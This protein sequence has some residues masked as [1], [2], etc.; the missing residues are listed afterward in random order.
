MEIIEEIY[1][2]VYRFVSPT[3]ALLYIGLDVWAGGLLESHGVTWE[4]LAPPN[5]P[6][7][8]F[9]IRSTKKLFWVRFVPSV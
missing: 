1:K 7:N 4:R 2:K 5:S 8:N 6:Q 9:K 3:R